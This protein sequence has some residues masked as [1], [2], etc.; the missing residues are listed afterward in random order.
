MEIPETELPDT[1]LLFV[2]PIAALRSYATDPP[3]IKD[4][5]QYQVGFSYLF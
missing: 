4:H 1:L 2:C 5:S 3:S